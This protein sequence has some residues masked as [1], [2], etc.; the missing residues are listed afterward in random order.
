MTLMPSARPRSSGGKT[1]VT[2]AAEVAASSAA[3]A[4]C[5]MRLPISQRAVHAEAG[6]QRARA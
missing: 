3:P 4:P 1:A 5:T 2:I 6:E